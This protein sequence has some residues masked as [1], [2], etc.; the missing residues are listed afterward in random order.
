[1]S[2]KRSNLCVVGGCQ[3][4]ATHFCWIAFDAGLIHKRPPA[5]C[6]THFDELTKQ[7]EA[8]KLPFREEVTENGETR[9]GVS[10]QG[11]GE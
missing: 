9:S 2:K 4:E 11:K 5:V 7:A 8:C 10:T 1:M 3:R 6:A